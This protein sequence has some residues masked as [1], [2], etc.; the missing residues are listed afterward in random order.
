MI[1]KREISRLIASLFDPLNLWA[2]AVLKGKSCLSETYKLTKELKLHFKDWKKVDNSTKPI[3]IN[4]DT[5][6]ETLRMPT[7]EL[8]KRLEELIIDWKEFK[9]DIN[10]F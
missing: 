9:Q 8:Q 2:P 10:N 7:M 5:N 6:L 1:S 3:S 4:W